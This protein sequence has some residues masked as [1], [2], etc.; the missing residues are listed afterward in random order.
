MRQSG[1]PFQFGIIRQVMSKLINP[2]VPF[3]I[4]LNS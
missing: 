3:P 2:R 4:C 1:F